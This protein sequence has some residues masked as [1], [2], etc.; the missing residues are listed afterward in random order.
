MASH[1]KIHN[2]PSVGRIRFRCTWPPGYIMSFPFPSQLA[3]CFKCVIWWLE[4]CD[5][6][7]SLWLGDIVNSGIG[8]SYQPPNLNRQ[9]GRYNKLM[10]KLTFSPNRSWDWYTKMLMDTEYKCFNS[11]GKFTFYRTLLVLKATPSFYLHLHPT[12]DLSFEVIFLCQN[13]DSLTSCFFIFCLS[14]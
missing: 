4:S 11:S 10:P 13:L 2:I 7:L 14:P 9:M 12:F 8:L 1:K 6:I 5:Q 3:Y